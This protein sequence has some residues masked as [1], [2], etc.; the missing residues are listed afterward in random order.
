M[1]ENTEY[2][3]RI[4]ETLE[5]L[6][7]NNNDTLPTNNNYPAGSSTIQLEND[8]LPANND[9]PA[10]RNSLQ[11]G[12]GL[13]ESVDKSISNQT[14]RPR[15]QCDGGTKQLKNKNKTKGKASSE[16][17]KKRAIERVKKKI[18]EEKAKEVLSGWK[19]INNLNNKSKKNCHSEGDG[20]IRTL[21]NIGFSKHEV[22]AFLAVGGFRVGRIMIEMKKKPGE[23]AEPRPPPGHAATENDIQQVLEYITSLDLE[24]GYPCSHRKIPL[25]VVG[26]H[27]GATW[28]ILHAEYEKLCRE[29]EVRIL[30]C[31]R[32]REYAKHYFPAIKLGKTQTDM[33]NDCYSMSLK[34]KDPDLT[35]EEKKEIKLKLAIHLDE[36]NIQRRAMNAF[37]KAVKRRV[38]PND[39]PF[40]FEP[41]HIPEVQ[42]EVLSEALHQ[43][44]KVTNPAIA[45][46]DDII[47]E[48]GEEA[49]M[50]DEESVEIN[51]VR[52]GE[53]DKGPQNLL[54]HCS[55]DVEGIPSTSQHD[56]DDFGTYIE[57]E[58][59]PSPSKNN[60]DNLGTGNEEVNVQDN[61]EGSIQKLTQKAKDALIRNLANR[62]VERREEFARTIT[63][64][65]V[66][67][68]DLE[69][70]DFG[71]E[72]LLPS[73]KQ[74]RPG[75]DYFNSS[76]NIREGF[77]KNF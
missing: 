5:P 15:S 73:F 28:K 22:T 32:F 65:V 14:I 34:L 74:R 76:V 16:T 7:T 24:P 29:K 54:V 10:G 18:G 21:L 38:A 62:T 50:E 2:I 47:T 42:D 69:I 61:T 64:D 39:P 56:Q 17:V 1:S 9:I 8:T 25:Y 52:N 23:V 72:K 58:I 68:M 36:A 67:K 31:N 6:P 20:V 49:E 3:D 75:A 77:N 4:G 40:R 35:T 11:L 57:E 26:D 46:Q 12:N 37:I 27:Q 51:L 41:C 30:S 70:E 63:D 33:C 71:A 48:E 19:E 45:G 55:W 60:Q 44:K 59:P 13:S 66:V 53:L 43:F